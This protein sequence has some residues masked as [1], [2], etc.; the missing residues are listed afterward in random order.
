[1]ITLFKA[2]TLDKCNSVLTIRKSKNLQDNN[3]ILPYDIDDGKGFHIACYHRFTA[4]AKYLDKKMPSSSTTYVTRSQVPKL[5]SPS[6]TGVLPKLC[7][8]CSKKDKKHN[9]TLVSVETNEFESNVKTY[10]VLLDDTKMLAKLGDVNFVSKEIQYHAICRTR[11]QTKAQQSKPGKKQGGE[12]SEWHR[13]RFIHADSFKSICDMIE[14]QVLTENEV[15]LMNTDGLKGV[16]LRNLRESF[17][18]A[19]GDSQKASF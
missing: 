12:S 18:S 3:V 11:Y 2:D 8:F 16:I 14:I 1:M 13:S 5:A 4:I 9:N 10:A 17:K 7:I 6:T 19:C 15:Y